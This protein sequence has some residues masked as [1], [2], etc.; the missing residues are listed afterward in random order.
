MV[1]GLEFEL[2]DSL[3]NRRWFPTLMMT[4]D[5]E[6]GYTYICYLDRWCRYH[7]TKGIPAG[8]TSEFLSGPPAFWIEHLLRKYMATKP[9]PKDIIPVL[10][11]RMLQTLRDIDL[12]TEDDKKGELAQLVKG[13][14][15]YYLK[16]LKEIK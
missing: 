13:L 6:D 8:E 5:H 7:T 1:M 10:D 3:N 9:P 2:T 16:A 15:K 11:F 12:E 4:R 14:I